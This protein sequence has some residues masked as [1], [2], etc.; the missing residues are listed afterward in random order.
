MAISRF[1]WAIDG[2]L[3]GCS[4][5]GKSDSRRGRGE[6]GYTPEGDPGLDEDLDWLRDQ[7]ISAVLS[8]TETPLRPGALEAHGMA[9]LHLPIPD[10]QA[11]TPAEFERALTFIDQQRGQGHRV[12]VHCLQGQG[13]TATI[14]AAYLIRGGMTHD[15]A[16]R[17]LRSI[18]PG[19]IASDQQER[20]LATYAR[21]RD[22][23]L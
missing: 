13:R 10:M 11:P 4:R 14:L 22:W 3:A 9:G 6:G 12:A 20:A 21:Q 23:I 17:E 1:Y 5:P 8:L 19:A 2:A 15:D 18:C 16:V 7:G